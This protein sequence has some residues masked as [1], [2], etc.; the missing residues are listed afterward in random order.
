MV[1]QN[2]EPEAAAHP[3]SPRSTTQEG[4]PTN[5]RAP[6]TSKWPRVRKSRLS[7]LPE[8]DDKENKVEDDGDTDIFTRDKFYARFTANTDSLY[9]TVL[10]IIEERDSLIKELNKLHVETETQIKALVD[11]NYDLERTILH[12][13]RQ[14]ST[15]GNSNNNHSSKSTKLP[16]PDQLDDGQNPSFKS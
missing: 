1:R 8:V 9:T 13:S 10:S 15:S 11:E 6:T 5:A 14:D 2:T 12:Y 3:G 16:D 7:I 4:V